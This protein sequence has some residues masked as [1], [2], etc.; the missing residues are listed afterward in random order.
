MT[1]HLDDVAWLMTW[2]DDVAG[3]LPF[4]ELLRLLA[5]D[6]AMS[7]AAVAEGRDLIGRDLI[8]RGGRSRD[9]NGRQSTRDGPSQVKSSHGMREGAAGKAH[10]RRPGAKP[11][12]VKPTKPS[13]R[14]GGKAQ[15]PA[16]HAAV[17]GVAGP[18]APKRAS[19]AGY[20]SLAGLV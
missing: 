17:C 5:D 2:R 19:M 15:Q 7:V 1:W 14:E 9:G 12:Q 10:K 11:S 3:T 20:A 6:A 8:G 16:R 18:P 4:A 13:K